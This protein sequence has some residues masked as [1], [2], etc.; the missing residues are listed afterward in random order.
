MYQEIVTEIQQWSDSTPDVVTKMRS[1][2]HTKVRYVQL[3]VLNNANLI[4]L[5]DL[6][7]ASPITS[8]PLGLSE[9][10]IERGKNELV[11]HTGDTDSEVDSDPEEDT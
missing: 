2:W 7:G 1:R 8:G 6:A 10:A 5:S 9:E 4:Y 11:G 3:S